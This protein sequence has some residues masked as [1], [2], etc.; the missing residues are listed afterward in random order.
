MRNNLKEILSHFD[1]DTK[2]EPYGNGHINDTY[3]CDSNPGFILQRINTNVFKKPDEV[4][5]NIA[6]V[7]A[8]LRTKIIENGG[9]P[10]RETLNVIPT[11][12]GGDMYCA[13]SENYYRM[14][15]FIDNTVGYDVVENPI[16][17]RRAGSAFGKFQRM[18]DD[19]NVED[20]FETIPNFHY[21]PDRVEQLKSA[22][23]KNYKNRKEAVKSELD[24]A[25]KYS[26]Y[27]SEIVDAMKNGDVP[28]RVTHND[29]KLNNVLFD[30]ATDEAICVIDLDTV[31]GGSLLYDYG[32]ALRFGASSAAEDETDLDKVFFDLEK[33]E[34]FTCG[35]LGEVGDCLTEREIEL[36]P[37]SVLILT[38]ECGI[39]F[40]ADYL[41]GD[42]Y[43]KI[44]RE[45]HNLDR[46]RTQLKLV[47]DIESKLGEMG[48]IV[49]KYLK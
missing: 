8:H 3:L 42:T 2:I 37:L 19:F 7:T 21:T 12:D 10:D 17:L 14:Y 24:A 47:E 9:N 23:A 20:L 32:D 29:T 18:L 31:M 43:F 1:V 5:K 27:A 22:V 6:A 36:L 16:Q 46:A 13:D 30:K 28:N 11:K 39:R 34:E 33:F 41:N 25:M 4:M 38:Y 49:E 35:F 48:K 15:K 40:L 45:N 44:H 26:R